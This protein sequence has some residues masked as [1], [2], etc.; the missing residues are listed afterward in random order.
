[1]PKSCAQLGA[2]CGLALDGC[3][4]TIS[5][6]QCDAGFSCGAGGVSNVCGPGT[7]TPRTHCDAGM[8]CG[9]TL[10]GCGG[11]L[12]CGFCDGGTCGAGGMPFQCPCLP[13]ASCPLG[14]T[15][16]TWPNGCGTGNVNCGTCIAPDTCAGA[17]QSNVCGCTP[18][19]GCAPGACGPQPNGCGGTVMCP[20]TCSA[21]RSCTS[22]D[23]GASH[24]NCSPGLTDCGGTCIDVLTSAS[25]CGACGNLCP[26]GQS[27]TGGLCPCVDAGSNLDGHCCPQGWTLENHLA[28]GLTTTPR[29]Y[30]GPL[31]PSTEAAALTTCLQETDAGYGRAVAAMGVG[32]SALD[33]TAAPEGACGSF[34]HGRNSNVI[35]AE[36]F[37]Q[38]TKHACMI[39]CIAAQCVC[40][41]CSC[42]GSLRACS[43]K[44]Y[45]VMDPFGPRVEGPCSSDG[46]CPPGDL[47]RM[48]DCIDAGT[49][50]CVLDGDCASNNCLPR[51]SAQTGFCR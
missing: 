18:T 19:T 44:F 36:S 46:E 43:Q 21:G 20:F 16:G 37:G 22:T 41:T 26:S 14:K 4:N 29:C 40:T 11:L 1:M 33:S 47:C 7:C 51:G 48:G 28:N 38:V 50:W 42:S 25:N 39:G 17:G 5:C 2:Q 35:D 23:G 12:T 34:L 9:D 10:D 13:L 45:C 31:G 3:G 49:P 8:Q 15:C 32:A 27:C 30:K 6:G 24:C